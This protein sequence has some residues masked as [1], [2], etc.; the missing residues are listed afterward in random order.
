[1]L[2]RSIRDLL[3]DS[4][5]G[6]RFDK[7]KKTWFFDL[8]EYNVNW[9]V[10]WAQTNQFSVSDDLQQLLNDIIKAGARPYS[11]RLQR[12]AIGQ[13]EIENAASSLLEYLADR[14]LGLVDA[15]LAQ[16]ADWGSMLGYSV[17]EAIWQELEQQHGS[18]VVVFMRQRTYEMHGDFGQIDRVIRY[19][20]LVNR[21]P[22]VI[23]DPTPDSKSLG[24]YR[25]VL[26][27][28]LVQVG[29]AKDFEHVDAVALWSHRVI[30]YPDQIGRAH[31]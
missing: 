19:A 26:G 16:L 30:R 10:T 23:F 28:R 13:L 12:D 15:N 29:N 24:A 21:M 18:D 5:G 31:V 3:K 22:M 8:T 27:D 7:E 2:F 17:D 4:Q 1:M 9:V 11:I 6:A 14:G 25:D 20:Q